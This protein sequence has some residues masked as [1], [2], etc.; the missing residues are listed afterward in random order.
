MFIWQQTFRNR[1]FAG[2]C[3]P[4]LNADV[5]GR[6]GAGGKIP[7][8]RFTVFLAG[9]TFACS[10]RPTYE[11]QRL[12]HSFQNLLICVRHSTRGRNTFA[13]IRR[14]RSARVAKKII[15]GKTVLSV[16]C[17]FSAACCG[18]EYRQQ[19]MKAG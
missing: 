7:F 15:E 13:S 6:E 4:Y 9:V 3:S 19:E 5:S 12:F 8:E 2:K 17:S 11:P 18:Q 14:C 16:N 10:A 1:Q